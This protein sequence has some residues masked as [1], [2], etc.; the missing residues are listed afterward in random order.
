M[1]MLDGKVAVVT[2]SGRG[3]GRGIALALAAAGAKVV[4]NDLGGTL[5][6]ETISRM[7]GSMHGSEKTVAELHD[8]A[9]GIGRTARQRT[10][11]YGRIDAGEGDLHHRGGAPIS[12]AIAHDR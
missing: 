7:A 6:E 10:T 2:G 12:L 1:G 8:I 3:I 9:S 4:V 5:M 11:V